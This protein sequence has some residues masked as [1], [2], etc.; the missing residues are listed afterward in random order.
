MWVFKILEEGSHIL[1][2]IGTLVVGLE[3]IGPMRLLGLCTRWV[4]LLLISKQGLILLVNTIEWA[5]MG[6][7]LDNRC[8]WVLRSRLIREPQ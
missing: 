6:L 4:G 1:V 2:I 7:G 5:L 8:L 3:R